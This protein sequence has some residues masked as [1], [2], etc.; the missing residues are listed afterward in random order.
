VSSEQSGS[1]SQ[2]KPSDTVLCVRRSGSVCNLVVDGNPQR[3][4]HTVNVGRFVLIHSVGASGIATRNPFLYRGLGAAAFWCGATTVA[5][6]GNWREHA[7]SIRCDSLAIQTVWH[8]MRSAT[9]ARFSIIRQDRR[10]IPKPVNLI[11]MP[12]TQ[13]RITIA[14]SANQ[15]TGCSK[16]L[17]LQMIDIGR[18]GWFSV[19]QLWSIR[20]ANKPLPNKTRAKA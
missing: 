14:G 19:S 15:V 12:N 13:P 4:C 11:G 1:D 7:M 10:P 16:C 6:V 5:T 3:S 17:A 2:I 20:A 8:L 18:S 9:C